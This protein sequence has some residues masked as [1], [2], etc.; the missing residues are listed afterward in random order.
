MKKTLVTLALVATA[1]VSSY[2]QGWVTFTGGGSA[3]TKISTNSVVGGPATGLT[4]VNAGTVAST[5]YYA[6]FYSL[7][8][9]TVGGSQTAAIAGT[10]GIYAFN[11]AGWTFASSAFG[12]DYATNSSAGRLSSSVSD[13][14]NSLGTQVPS[15]AAQQFVVIGWSGNIGNTWQLAQSFLADPTSN[16]WIGQS[17][18]SG[19]I[20][21]GTGGVSFP[22]GLFGAAAPFIQGFTLGLVVPVPEP[23]TLALM[24]LGSASLLLF[25]RKK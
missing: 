3:A 10:N 8:A 7:A 17:G 1:A 25:R 20:T 16:G 5:Y 4:A 12:P 18:V 23:T 6:L 2:G 13:P 15:G 22:A 14:A 9:T 24:A 19:A 11:A 21:P